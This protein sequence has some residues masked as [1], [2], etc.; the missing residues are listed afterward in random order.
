MKK[1]LTLGIASLAIVGVVGAGSL[2]ASALNGQ[3][4]R[5]GT[6][7]GNGQGTSQGN[8]QGNGYQTSLESR[9]KVFGMSVEEL[10]KALETKT[11]SQI[12]VERGMNEETFRAKMTEQAKARWESRGLT[13]E[14]IAKR[15]ADREERQATNSADCESF[16]SGE[17]NRQGGYGQNR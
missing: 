17:G 15:T 8:G 9:A 1:I 7:A 13:S 5:T 4:N 6:Q 16:G 3:A 11:M 2:S 12:A 14:E 10:Q